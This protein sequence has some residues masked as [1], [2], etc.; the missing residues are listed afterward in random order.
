MNEIYNSYHQLLC[1]FLS[2]YDAPYTQSFTQSNIFLRCMEYILLSAMKMPGTN[3]NPMIH[4]DARLR[5]ATE[6]ALIK[7][8]APGNNEP[9]KQKY[10]L[11]GWS[12]P[13]SLKRGM[14]SRIFRPSWAPALSSPKQDNCLPVMWVIEIDTNT[15][16]WGL[17]WA[18]QVV[19]ETTMTEI[20]V[21]ISIL[22]W[23]N[24][25]NDK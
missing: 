12:S 22:S 14:C 9:V 8:I 17:W 4:S 19:N 11:V 16:A 5:V 23:W 3:E 6:E 13:I 2:N 24:W 7:M 1:C 25:I 20:E 15:T 18:S 10:I 21:S